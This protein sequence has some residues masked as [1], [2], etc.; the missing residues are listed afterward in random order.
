MFD[1]TRGEELT[2]LIAVALLGAAAS[3]VCLLRGDKGKAVEIPL[4]NSR[5]MVVQRKGRNPQGKILVH[6]SGEVQT[7]GVF[8]LG[9][10]SRIR[11]AIELARATENGDLESLN[12]A[13]TLVDGERIVVPGKGSVSGRKGQPGPAKGAG[14]IN[15]NTATQEELEFLPGIGPVIA[16]R[17]VE[18][19]KT[20]KFEKVDDLLEV[21]RIGP[22]T[23]EKVREYVC[24]K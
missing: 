6:V 18:F 15:V 2:A 9:A 3:A 1:L 12:L 22:V 14:A 17:I 24:V 11:D 10:G 16:A 7:K 8:E 4:N 13:A 23:L 19:R 21:K 20:R 5:E